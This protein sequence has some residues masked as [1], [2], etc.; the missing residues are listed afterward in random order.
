[1][2]RTAA[3]V[4]L[5]GYVGRGTIKNVDLDNVTV[6][7]TDHVGGLVGMNVRGNISSSAVEGTVTGIESRSYGIG[8]LVGSNGERVRP[9]ADRSTRPVPISP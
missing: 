9:W 4:G 3:E 6:N 8:G 5:F 1:M 7:R 2:N